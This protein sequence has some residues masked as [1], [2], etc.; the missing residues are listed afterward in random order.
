MLGNSWV[1]TEYFMYCTVQ[2]T[3][4]GP[5]HKLLSRRLRSRGTMLQSRVRTEPKST[6]PSYWMHEEMNGGKAF[7]GRNPQRQASEGRG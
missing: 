4:K 7:A 3:I 6:P 2:Y 1:G 5:D